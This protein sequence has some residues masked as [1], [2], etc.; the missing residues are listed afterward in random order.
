MANYA[1]MNPGKGHLG[2]WYNAPPYH[3]R[4]YND[5]LEPYK[6]I[7][8]KTSVLHNRRIY[9][10]NVKVEYQDG[11][12]ETLSDTILKS[13][14]AQFDKFTKR[15]RIDVAVGDGEDIIKL[16]SYADRILE[17]K[18]RTLHVI[19][20]SA[21]GEFLE[22]SFKYKGVSNPQAVARTDYGVAWANE[23][24]CYMYDGRQIHDLLEEN[25][26]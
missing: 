19:N 26:N 13:E 10:G 25:V 24:G 21:K 2:H 12:K 5:E 6:N 3:Q 20:A 16:E 22:D 9:L 17:F 7:Q 15:G 18:N 23:F 11:K 14:P 4:I 1:V 8:F